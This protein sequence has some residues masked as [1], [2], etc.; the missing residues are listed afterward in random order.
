MDEFTRRA[1]LARASMFGAFVSAGIALPGV[2]PPTS[3]LVG[4]AAAQTGSDAVDAIEAWVDKESPIP[5]TDLR[6]SARLQQS[7]L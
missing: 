2:M 1:F 3:G 7:G 6:I 5:S 4:R